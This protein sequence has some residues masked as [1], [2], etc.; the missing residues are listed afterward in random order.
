MKQFNP[1]CV[2]EFLVPT[3]FP[4]PGTGGDDPNR[5]PKKPAATDHRHAGSAVM[6][7]MLKIVFWLLFGIAIL[8]VLTGL[9]LFTVGYQGDPQAETAYREAVVRNQQFIGVVDIIGGVL[10]AGLTARLPGGSRLARRALLVVLFLGCLANLLAFGIRA[11]GFALALIAVLLG[12]AALML[13]H[14]S[15]N[16]YIDGFD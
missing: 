7:S 16:S 2:M 8:M 12:V 13:F 11:G 14:S 15:I 3:M 1:P 10:I 4:T 5:R 9:V 6:P